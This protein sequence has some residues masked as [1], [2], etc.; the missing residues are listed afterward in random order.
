MLA[1]RLESPDAVG[2]TSDDGFEIGRFS[3]ESINLLLFGAAGG[4][5][6]GALYVLVRRAIPPFARVASATLIGAT[7]GGS[8]FLNPDGDDLQVLD[9]LWLAVTG[10]IALPALAALATALLVE[11]WSRIAPWSI[12]RR[13]ALA[14]APALFAA[15]VAPVLAAGAAGVV[16][17]R[18]VGGLAWLTPAIRIVVPVAVLAI[19]VTQGLALIGEINRIL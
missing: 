2:L 14:F 5:L 19:V 6:F 11:R 13:Q 15:P 3:F 10:F 1:L 18:R 12:S 16:V 4:A 9:P 17:V 7:V 8:T